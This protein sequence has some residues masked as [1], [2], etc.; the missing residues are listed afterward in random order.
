MI[1]RLHPPG[2]PLLLASRCCSSTGRSWTLA[3]AAEFTPAQR[4][5]IVAIVRD[6]LKQDPSIL[7][8]AVIALQADEGDEP[9][10]DPRRH[11]CNRRT[12]W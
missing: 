6:A 1:R 9:S 7:R 3:R 8:D 5:E 4:A 12:S 10:S 11:R 2:L